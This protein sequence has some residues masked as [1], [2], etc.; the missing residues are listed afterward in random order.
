M[1]TVTAAQLVDAYDELNPDE[2]NHTDIP[3]YLA[4]TNGQGDPAAARADVERIFNNWLERYLQEPELAICTVKTAWGGKVTAALFKALGIKQPRTKPA[5]LR[6]LME[7]NEIV[8]QYCFP[9]GLIYA[10]RTRDDP[11]TQD[12]KRLAYLN[13]ASLQL[14]LEPDCKGELADY[15]KTEAAKIQAM[16]GQL[17]SI[18]G[19]MKVILGSEAV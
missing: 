11:R 5:M 10:D 19:N 12:Y 2:H 3:A 16:K 9:T 18:A 8:G 6:A 15:V 4:R 14:D 13:Y 1:K 7:M 17:F